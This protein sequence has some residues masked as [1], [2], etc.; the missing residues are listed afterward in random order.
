MKELLC[1]GV[2]P[3][4]IEWR[5][6]RLFVLCTI[7]LL[8]FTAADMAL[9][10]AAATTDPFA[11]TKLASALSNLTG[12]LNGGVARSLAVLAVI[13]SGIAALTGRM[14][15]SRAVVVILGVGLIFSASTIIDK[16]F[17]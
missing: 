8:L 7:A 14:E 11:S 9:A 13:G 17:A 5:V 15:W 16:L 6:G 12:A 1:V 10:Q 3:R 2:H 4:R